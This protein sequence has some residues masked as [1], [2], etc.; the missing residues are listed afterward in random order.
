MTK[1]RELLKKDWYSILNE[2]FK[3]V[4]NEFENLKM[5]KKEI[6][7]EQI[8]L[9]K[10][11][12]MNSNLDNKIKSKKE[13]NGGDEI[14]FFLPEKSR[15]IL[16]RLNISNYKIKKTSFRNADSIFLKKI[17]EII[18]KT[19]AKKIYK[20]RY[21]SNK[22]MSINLTE[23]N[24]TNKKKFLT[25]RNDKI[26]S[27][28]KKEGNI[29]N[30]R[31]N[32]YLLSKTL[33]NYRNN[34]RIVRI[35]NT[36]FP[37]IKNRKN[38]KLNIDENDKKRIMKIVLSEEDNTI[39]RGKSITNSI[40]KLNKDFIKNKRL[41]C[42]YKDK[43]KDYIILNNKKIYQLKFEN[44]SYIKNFV[45]IKKIEDIEQKLLDDK[46]NIFDKTKKNLIFKYQQKMKNNTND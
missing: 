30:S 16:N 33:N 3:N 6:I 15:I 13:I 18:E 38:E 19:N 41:I 45:N 28:N 8:K 36:Y 25:S 20:T 23:N 7:N 39:N 10:I 32:N 35:N 37:K 2:N 40:L 5:K 26:D 29:N 12:L 46:N 43:D 11:N 22:T 44:K 42:G 9:D 27:N 34:K 14:E 31:N 21:K 1:N 24:F 17:L 4:N